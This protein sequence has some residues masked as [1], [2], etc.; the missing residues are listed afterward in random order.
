MLERMRNRLILLAFTVGAGA[1]LYRFGLTKEARDGIKQ[2]I[3]T[4]KKAYSQIESMLTDMQGVT[5]QES[6][7]PNRA[8]TLNQWEKLGY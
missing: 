1:L 6:V 7:L 3:S 8:S 4:S 5:V 2:V